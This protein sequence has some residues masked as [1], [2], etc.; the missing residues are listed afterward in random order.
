MEGIEDRETGEISNM[1]QTTKEL[2]HRLEADPRTD[3]AIITAYCRIISVYGD[4]EDAR[5]LFRVFAEDPSDYRR[6]LLL[7]PVMRC[8]G[9]EL[10]EDIARVTFD[11]GSLREDMP[12]DILHVLGYMGYEK[13]M[14]Y[15]AACVCEDDWDL[16]KDACLGL[17][18]LPCQAYRERFESEWN[19]VAGQPLFPEFLPALSYTFADERIV[20]KLMSWGKT[21]STDCNAGLLLGISMFGPSQKE[22]V[23]QILMDPFWELNS[24]G[25][26]S[27]W[28]A[29]MCMPMTGLT[30]AEIIA[31]LKNRTPVGGG[32]GDHR[33]DEIW[34]GH[35]YHVLHDLIEVKLAGDP[36]PIKYAPQNTEKM[37]D[38]Y[39]DLFQWSSSHEDDS[40]PG[41]ISA[42]LGYD[43]PLIDQY[44]G[45]RMKME[46]A[47]Q[48]ELEMDLMRK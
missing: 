1:I 38:L 22:R 28:W 44:A 29:Y 24:T 3:S 34:I 21:A 32:T 13:Y 4:D 43:H 16:S 39:R 14:D 41:R 9:L 19:K 37:I 23:R 36:H 2:I 6:V 18:H 26:G 12:S 47:L 48:K 42:Y 7:D 8:G 45:L 46:M 25:T 31:D 35:G 33:P 40:V 17:L 15:M 10:A 20:P 30:F 5:A 11:Q 27:H